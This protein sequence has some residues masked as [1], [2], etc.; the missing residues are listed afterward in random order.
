MFPYIFI[1][2]PLAVFSILEL[3][4]C[5]SKQQKLLFF[6]SFLLLWLFSGLRYNIGMDYPAYKELYENSLSKLNPDIKELGWAYLFYW[7]RNI[8]C[9]FEFVILTI[10]FF[11]VYY[12]FLFIKRYSPYPFMSILIFFCFTQYYT[13]TFNVMRQCLA[14]YI[15]FVSLKHIEERNILKY[16]V[17]I[18]II[19]F[20]VHLT[21]I[22]LLPLYFVLHKSYPTLV[23]VGIAVL[24]ILAVKFLILIIA[25]SETYRIYL[26]FEQYAQDITITTYIL[27]F[28]SSLFLIIEKYIKKNRVDNI[29][30]NIS[31]I[32]LLCFLVAYFF[33][34][35]PLVIVFLRFAYY[36]TPVLIVLLPL[37]VKKTFSIK[38]Q[39]L[40]LF[41][42]GVS[43]ISIFCYTLSAGGE[44]NKLLPYKTVLLK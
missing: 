13:Y 30:L 14:C 36:F 28:I 8:E 37:L 25:S 12:V 32:A 35:T 31:F 6:V 3:L 18:G 21:A 5:V 19:A 2:I 4:H 22:I 9:P 23:K 10:S 29:L 41:F 16:A 44:K 27:I 39:S 24:S 11:T 42:I 43:Y 15:F 7:F 26:A 17:N 1:L 40:I 33:T 38:S 20:C 34:G